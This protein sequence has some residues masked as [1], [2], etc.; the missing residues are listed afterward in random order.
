[1]D[2]HDIGKNIVALAFEN[3]TVYVLST[4][5]KDVATEKIL[6]TRRKNKNRILSA[7]CRA[8]D[9]HNVNMKDEVM[10]TGKSAEYQN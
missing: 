6:A 10:D 1:V 7:C 2:I 4:L 5:G 8:D 9:H 3:I